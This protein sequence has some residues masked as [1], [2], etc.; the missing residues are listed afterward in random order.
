MPLVVHELVVC[1]VPE[2]EMEWPQELEQRCCLFR[3]RVPPDQLN[4][5]VRRDACIDALRQASL[6]CIAPL[7][8]HKVGN[9][10]LLLS[11]LSPFDPH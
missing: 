9:V 6:P 5:R 10:P 7:C 1:P 11:T 3:M 2:A 4:P 8:Q